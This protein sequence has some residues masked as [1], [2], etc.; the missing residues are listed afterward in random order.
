MTSPRQRMLED[1]EI[2]HYS[3]ITI[4]V[5]LR[6]VSEFADFRKPPDLP[7]QFNR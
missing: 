5:Y 3:S 1:L 7:I 4:W 2:R 6:S